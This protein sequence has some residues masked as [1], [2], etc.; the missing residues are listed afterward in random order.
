MEIDVCRV[1]KTF[2]HGLQAS[3]CPRGDS[4]GEEIGPRGWGPCL[5]G[6][7]AVV[8]SVLSNC[9]GVRRTYMLLTSK[10]RI[11]RSRDGRS[12]ILV[13]SLRMSSV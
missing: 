5:E 12:A 3:D 10:P 2:G 13:Q 9:N 8:S 4:R 6:V 11:A 1:A 7:I